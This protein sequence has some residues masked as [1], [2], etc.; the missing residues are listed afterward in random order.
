MKIGIVA[1]PHNKDFAATLNQVVQWLQSR[2]CKTVVEE[3]IVQV[4]LLDNVLTA[5][6]EK[7]PALVDVIV[8]FGGTAPCSRWP[9]PFKVETLRSSVSMSVLSDS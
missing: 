4:P 6:R 7:I 3:S 5:P 2:D 9:A 8:V 1:K